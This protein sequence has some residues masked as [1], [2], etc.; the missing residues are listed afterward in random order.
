MTENLQ[1]ESKRSRRVAGD[2]GV[3]ALA[4]LGVALFAVGAL[5]PLAVGAHAWEAAVRWLGLA[6]VAA[7]GRRGS[8]LTYW[9][10]FSMLLGAE[11]GLDRPHLAEHL[12]FLSDVFLR[13]IKVIVAPLILGTLITGIAGHGS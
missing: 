7:G 9:I 8:S 6:F 4:Y 1:A 10:L 13:L 11:V 3:R 5:L 12:R 2:G